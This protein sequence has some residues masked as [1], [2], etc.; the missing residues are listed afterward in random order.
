M[1]AARKQ[2]LDE[3]GRLPSDKFEPKIIEG[4]RGEMFLEVRGLISKLFEPFLGRRRSH[5]EPIFA[6]EFYTKRD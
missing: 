3:S 1:D 2:L 5:A 4:K 6:S